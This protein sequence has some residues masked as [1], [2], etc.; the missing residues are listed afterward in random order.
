MG[1]ADR[2]PLVTR[3]RFGAVVI[4]LEVIIISIIFG[5]AEYDPATLGPKSKKHDAPAG[6]FERLY[7]QFQD[8]HVMIFIGFGFLM[9]F[10]RRYGMAAV[11][12]NL[13]I[14]CLSIQ[15]ALLTNGFFEMIHEEDPC[16]PFKDA[17]A[18]VTPVAEEGNTIKLGLTS[19]LKA[20]FTSAAILI[21]FGAVIGV[22]SPLQLVVMVFLETLLMSANEHIGVVMLKTVDA[23]D[24]IFVHL[25]G[26][27]YGLA[28]SWILYKRAKSRGE[29]NSLKADHPKEGSDYKS[30]IFSMIGAVFLWCF[31]PSFNAA[32]SDGFEAQR[33]IFNTY[34]SLVTCVLVTAALSSALD[35]GGKF[36]PV[37]IQNSTLAGG[38]AVGT[39]ANM[40]LGPGGA[41]VIGAVAAI[42][43][44]L[45]FKYVTPLLLNKLEIHDTCGVHNLHGMP[46]VLAAVGS[47]FATLMATP[48]RYEESLFAV[49]PTMRPEATKALCDAD[50]LQEF[51]LG[52]TKEQQAARQV[53]AM[54]VTF[55]IAIAGGV[56]S[57]L[58]MDMPIW[59]RVTDNQLFE[60]SH[61]WVVEEEKVDFIDAMNNTI[62]AD[63]GAIPGE[64]RISLAQD[65]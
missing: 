39:M 11:G 65:E 35:D 15:W 4:L 59:Q 55:V 52:F 5:T 31:W 58:I 43:S 19:M 14:A 42:V 50:P 8:V 22:A 40:M 18:S 51:G 16:V 33:V 7:P 26:A 13:I 49:F 41:M 45:G 63:Y 6:G 9:T 3:A 30:D 10:L 53:V 44:V 36:D 2:K 54:L 62:K 48:A 37:H 24:S 28:V 25:F 17:N 46:A 27:Y 12:V 32:T 34:A 21:S 20:D 64:D 1:E 23:G 29:W 47:I 60:D 57:G 38:V 56:L 61:T